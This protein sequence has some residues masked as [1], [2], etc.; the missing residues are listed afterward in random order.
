MLCILRQQNFVLNYLENGKESELGNFLKA[1]L[2]FK[3][4]I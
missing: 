1:L 3:D 2:Y 4:D